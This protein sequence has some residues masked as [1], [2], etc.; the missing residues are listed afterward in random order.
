MTRR[1]YIHVGL[2]AASLLLTVLLEGYP[3]FISRQ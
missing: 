1:E 3:F 2:A